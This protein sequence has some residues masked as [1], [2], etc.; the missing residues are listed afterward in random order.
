MKTFCQWSLSWHRQSLITSSCTVPLNLNGCIIHRTLV[1]V[2]VNLEYKSTKYTGYYGEQKWEISNWFLFLLKYLALCWSMLHN[3][4]YCI[5]N[6]NINLV[7]SFINTTPNLPPFQIFRLNFLYIRHIADPPSEG[8][9]LIL[10]LNYHCVR[11]KP[12]INKDL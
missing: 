10:L 5:I 12:V 4:C 6:F 1:H 11:S 3:Y 2:H 7:N 9:S 8:R